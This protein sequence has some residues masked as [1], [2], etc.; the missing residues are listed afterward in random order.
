[1]TLLFSDLVDSTALSA[2]VDSEDLRE[3][4]AA[5]QKCSVNTVL[6]FGGYVAKH[7]GDGVLRCGP[8]RHCDRVLWR[9]ALRLC[10]RAGATKK[11]M[12]GD[13]CGCS[14]GPGTEIKPGASVEELR[15]I[16]KAHVITPKRVKL[17]SK[18]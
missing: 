5:Y 9:A 1:V 17:T 18:S 11:S 14:L 2:R 4:I 10:T 3:V 16:A 13:L 8:G 12:C 6:R 15:K 7:M